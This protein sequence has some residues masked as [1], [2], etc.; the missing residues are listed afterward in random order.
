MFETVILTMTDFDPSTKEY[1]EIHPFMDDADG[2]ETTVKVLQGLFPQMTEDEAKEI[3]RSQR[4]A[5]G[6]AEAQ[7]RIEEALAKV[8][9]ASAELL[10]PY[11]K[12][13]SAA[14][15]DKVVSD[16]TEVSNEA[17]RSVSNDMTAMVRPLHILEDLAMSLGGTSKPEDLY[18]EQNHDQDW[19]CGGDHDE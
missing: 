6:K 16:L 11:I 3:I 5:T 17:V 7:K 10:T 9:N 15:L 8:A 4:Y 1:T 19:G 18:Q 14:T 12:A 2:D 13:P